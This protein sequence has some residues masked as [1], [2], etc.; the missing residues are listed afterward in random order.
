MRLTSILLILCYL[1]LIAQPVLAINQ[2]QDMEVILVKGGSLIGNKGSNDGIFIGM[3]FEIH[4]GGIIIGRAEVK[5]IRNNKCGLK[6]R[7]RN[8]G[9]IPRTGDTL[10]QVSNITSEGQDIFNE[11]QETEFTREK[12]TRDGWSDIVKE[13]NNSGDSYY[14]GQ[15]AADNDY[16]SAF[17]G[18]VTAGILGGLIGWGIGYAIVS[19]QGAT[20]PPRYLTNLKT[21]QRMQFSVGYKEKIKSKRKSTFNKGA[22]TGTI[23]IVGIFLVAANSQ[24]Q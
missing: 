15:A 6:I 11:I 22:L 18:G 2:P 1:S 4:Q 14:D 24:S 19:S 5:V 20:V 16:G 21:D 12:L 3:I 23:L 8:S 17:S 10:T 7:E 13:D 9:Y